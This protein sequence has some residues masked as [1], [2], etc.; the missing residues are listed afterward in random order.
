MKINSIYKCVLAIAF[1]ARAVFMNGCHGVNW[2][3]F[4]A[5]HFLNCKYHPDISRIFQ[6]VVLGHNLL[7]YAHE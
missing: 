3:N 7:L 6:M 2:E 4:S 5:V 1:F